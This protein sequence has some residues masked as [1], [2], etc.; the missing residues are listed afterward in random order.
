MSE[1]Q[2]DRARPTP[3]AGHRVSRSE[4]AS[5]WADLLAPGFRDHLAALPGAKRPGSIP[6]TGS[7]RTGWSL[8]GNK[9]PYA[10]IFHLPVESRT[11]TP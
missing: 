7:K 5:P 9:R 8:V 1:P 6:S 2:F 11:W 4:L 10:A 3:I